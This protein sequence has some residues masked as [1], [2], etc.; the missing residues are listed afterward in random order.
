MFLWLFWPLARF[1]AAL[2]EPI[3]ME[4]KEVDR[5]FGFRQS[6]IFEWTATPL[7][8][9]KSE[10]FS[11]KKSC[12]EP[13]K[14]EVGFVFHF[15]LCTRKWTAAWSAASI[16]LSP[17]GTIRC[18]A[19]AR[20]ATSARPHTAAR[21]LISLWPVVRSSRVST[22]SYMTVQSGRKFSPNVEFVITTERWSLKKIVCGSRIQSSRQIKPFFLCVCISTGWRCV[23]IIELF[24]G[25][26]ICRTADKRMISAMIWRSSIRYSDSTCVVTCHLAI[27]SSAR[28]W[29]A[30]SNGFTQK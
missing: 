6:F 12:R 7:S 22:G 21:L 14:K 9:V 23:T 28:Q 5:R 2:V 15:R 11:Q 24:R 17:P 16:C 27:A 26:S 4:E 20:P 3:S 10:A 18:R 19:A 1:P 13:E 25:Q 29:I 30:A 8:L